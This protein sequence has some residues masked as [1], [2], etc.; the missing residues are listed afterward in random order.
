VNVTRGAAG[1]AYAC[2]M[3]IR[4][5]VPSSGLYLAALGALLG[6][7]R[8]DTATLD[9]ALSPAIAA[10]QANPE[11]WTE[12]DGE[13][14]LDLDECD[15]VLE[16]G[17]HALGEVEVTSDQLAA[18]ESL[19]FDG[20]NEIYMWFEGAV[21]R[22]LGLK[23]WA[24]DTGGESDL[25]LVTTL[26]GLAAMPGIRKLHLYAYGWVYAERDASPLA[27]LSGLVELHLGNAKFSNLDVLL[28]LP[29]LRKLRGA[30]N[31]SEELR[32]RLASAGV[33]FV[34]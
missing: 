25:Y 17:V 27:A 14:T 8:I 16:V 29:A 2:I 21:A 4:E 33:E 10:I 18:I 11:F 9:A 1:R 23:E 3:K 15:A 20:G 24:L 19:D 5:A 31:L 22:R 30:E 34:G 32:D 13:R 12:E 6:S 7:E 26:D 28:E